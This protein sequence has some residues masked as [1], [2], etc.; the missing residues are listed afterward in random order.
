MSKSDFTWMPFYRE[1][2]DKL[3]PYRNKRDQLINI[4]NG[5]YT[6]IGQKNPLKSNSQD[7]GIIDIDPFTV[8]GLI[9]RGITFENRVI[10]L[11]EFKKVF[12]M[13]SDIPSDFDGVPQFNNMRVWLFPYE[14]GNK[15]SEFNE[16]DTL[17]KV[18]IEAH[19]YATKKNNRKNLVDA[20][21]KAFALRLIRWNITI[22]LYWYFSDNFICLD[23]RTREYLIKNG[24]Y[25][26]EEIDSVLTDSNVYLRICEEVISQAK[27]NDVSI[28]D[29][30]DLSAAAYAEV[31]KAKEE[32]KLPSYYFIC[33]DPDIFSFEHMAVGDSESFTYKN[34]KGNY[35][36]VRRNFKSI[37]KGDIVVCYDGRPT[38]KVVGLAEIIDNDPDNEI[39]LVKTRHFD[40]PID[41]EML[42]NSPIIQGSEYFKISR[43]TLFK[44]TKEE[45]EEIISL[46]DG[47]KAPTIVSGL[48]KGFNEL[49]YGIPGCGK[50]YAVNKRVEDVFGIKDGDDN[51]IRTT[52]YLDY[53]YNDFVGQ[54]MPQSVGGVIDYKIKA[55][56][57]TTALAEAYHGYKNNIPVVL[58][59]EEINRGNAPAIFGDIFQLLDRDDN[60]ESEYEIT[61]IVVKQYLEENGIT[62][63]FGNKIRIPKNLWIFATMNSSDQNVFKLDTAFKRRWDMKRMTNS[64]V[65]G[66]A[67]AINNF[68]IP[69]TSTSW[70]NFV[71]R[72]NDIL[73]R[74]DLNEDRQLGYWFVLKKNIDL[75]VTE[76]ERKEY[77]ANK[78]LEYLWNDVLKFHDKILFN[79]DITSF[80]VLIDEYMKDSEKVFSV[81][82]LDA[83]EDSDSAES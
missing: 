21:D 9:N 71:D 48:I 60:G 43:G 64:S 69:G 52:F 3:L 23:G 36:Q 17:W 72:V 61:N 32:A 67:K 27:K 46:L 82:L 51:K 7:S 20:L 42:K 30:R 31:E 50:S 47:T 66:A 80:D 10:A 77:F 49:Y 37:K 4:L 79:S 28:N 65:K 24:F 73:L 11:T 19:K 22:G 56:P 2:A 33:A 29:L 16:I 44:L 18:F 8:L 26:E 75:L 76:D 83:K 13:R 41:Y 35:R 78:V 53:S 45:Y 58:I 40:N 68:N 57:F 15:T 74:D 55:G 1:L 54:L 12:K 14:A 63:P 70:I 81:G 38:Q 25:N 34:D 62:N 6:T 59:I 5:V 39:K